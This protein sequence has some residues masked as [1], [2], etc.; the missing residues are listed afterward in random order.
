LTI[1]PKGKSAITPQEKSPELVIREPLSFSQTHNPCSTQV[2]PR[3]RGRGNGRRPCRSHLPQGSQGFRGGGNPGRHRMPGR[4]LPSSRFP[5][6]RSPAVGPPARA[7]ANGSIRCCGW[8]QEPQK[9]NTFSPI[10]DLLRPRLSRQSHCRPRIS[11]RPWG[12]TLWR[13]RRG[14]TSAPRHCLGS[15]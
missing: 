14:R 13:G 4:L 11:E 7:E 15:A 5:E 10:T 8:S 6:V 3:L 9:K 2:E 1:S 12:D